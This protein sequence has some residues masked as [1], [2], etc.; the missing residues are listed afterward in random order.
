MNRNISLLY[1][2]LYLFSTTKT[3]VEESSA[4]LYRTLAGSIARS[5]L[6]S[7]ARTCCGPGPVLPRAV[8]RALPVPRV[9]IPVKDRKMR[10]FSSSS[11]GFAC[12]A[13]KEIYEQQQGK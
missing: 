7:L 2:Y 3:F 5:T 13:C 12:T 8:A 6:L 11:S 4:W 10:L 1:L 9:I